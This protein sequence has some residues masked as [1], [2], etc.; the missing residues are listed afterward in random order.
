[1]KTYLKTNKE[2]T[3]IKLEVKYSKG[4]TALFTHK[5]EK[6]KPEKYLT[7]NKFIHNVFFDGYRNRFWKRKEYK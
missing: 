4:G 3:F 6:I 1:M 2:N 5:I 7:V